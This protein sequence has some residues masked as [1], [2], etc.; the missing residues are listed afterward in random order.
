MTLQRFAKVLGAVF[1]AVGLLGFVPG[2]VSPAPVERLGMTVQT[3]FGY[4]LGLFAVNVLHNVVHLG[5]GLWGWIASRTPVA[6]LGFS[7][8]V[9]VFYGA[10]TVMGLIPG[11][12][13]TLGFIPLFGH[14][15]WLHALT[16]LS[17][18]YFGYYWTDAVVEVEQETRRAA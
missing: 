16:A 14:D 9:A 11:L 12:D 1:I 15:V 4:L 18:A 7:R 3:G 17:A 13:T 2:M 5:I 8:G 6:A 10:L